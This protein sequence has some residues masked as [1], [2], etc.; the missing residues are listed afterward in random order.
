MAKDPSPFHQTE[1]HAI[2]DIYTKEGSLFGLKQPNG[3]I[4]INYNQSTAYGELLKIAKITGCE[5]VVVHGTWTFL[6]HRETIVNDDE[7]I[8][9]NIQEV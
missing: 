9:S 3:N 6:P 2:G 1:F 4:V 8:G 5:V 7:Q